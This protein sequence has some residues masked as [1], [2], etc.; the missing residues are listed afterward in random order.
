MEVKL[1]ISFQK[2]YNKINYKCKTNYT[3]A[4][5]CAKLDKFKYHKVSKKYSLQKVKV[6][7]I[8][9]VRNNQATI[10]HAINSVLNQD[11]PDIEYIIVDGGS[12]DNT[13]DIIKFYGNKIS[14]F[15]SES[16]KGMYD[17][18]NKGLKLATGDIIGL[19]NSDDFY[20]H[21]RVISEVVEEFIRRKVELVFG[22]IVFVHPQNIGQIIRYYSSAKFH[23]DLLSWG[24]IPAHTSCFLKREVY[25]KYGCFKTNYQIAADY[26]LLLRFIKVHQISYIYLPKVLVRMR[27]GGASNKNLL[28]RWIS[29]QEVLKACSEHGIQ[30]NFFKLLV[31]YPAKLWEKISI[32][33]REV[34]PQSNLNLIKKISRLVLNFEQK[35]KNI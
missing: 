28:C 8:T 20:E 18:M 24:W 35:S 14:K 5:A 6:S 4:I 19:L 26:E 12:N 7:I 22:D 32:N 17:G 1:P 9:V 31:R 16:D 21:N 11:Y 2:C 30:T 29:N 13:V 33:K 34:S 25:E 27:P 23:P 15:I 10:A 3:K